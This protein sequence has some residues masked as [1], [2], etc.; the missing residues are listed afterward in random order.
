[1]LNFMSSKFDLDKFESYL[2]KEK[3]YSVHTVASYTADVSSFIEFSEE[4]FE[5][6]NV[7]QITYIMIREWV[8]HLSE[9]QVASRSINRKI[10]SLRNYFLF[11]QKEGVVQKNPLAK[12]KSIKISKKIYP[13]I[14]EDEIK[15]VLLLL[16]KQKDFVAL[17]NLII[18]ELLYTT[19]IR[20]A[21]L[22]GLKNADFSFSNYSIKVTGKRNKERIIPLL[23]S[24]SQK[25]KS[26][27]EQKKQVIQTD[28]DYFFITIKGKKIYPNLVYRVVTYYLS[29]F[30][31]KEKVSPHVLRHSFA[32]HLLA[33]GADLNAVKDLL[34]H[35]SLSSTQIYTHNNPN[36]L[37]KTYLTSHPRSLKIDN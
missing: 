2:K 16:N 36:M 29:K 5:I 18:I 4:V 12:H 21:E 27:M 37:K 22:I 10:S 26:Y 35:A 31:V 32:T 1:M 25:I 34:G 11:M 30:S 6:K 33:N 14:S 17:R 23:K 8:V 3:K 19:G 13:P 15:Q 9:N 20:R 7:S 24:T 28:S